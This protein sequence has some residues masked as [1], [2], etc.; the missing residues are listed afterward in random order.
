MT[1]AHQISLGVHS[2]YLVSGSLDVKRVASTCASLAK[3][4]DPLSNHSHQG[5]PSHLKNIHI[6]FTTYARCIDME[7]GLARQVDI[8]GASIFKT[9]RIHHLQN[10]RRRTSP[11]N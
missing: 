5:R 4:V 8:P 7:I 2:S 3:L 11:T 1:E 10:D 9:S 6:A